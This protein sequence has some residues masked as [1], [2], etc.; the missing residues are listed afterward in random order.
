MLSPPYVVVVVYFESVLS[1]VLL[2]PFFSKKVFSIASTTFC[3]SLVALKMNLVDF[4]CLFYS[5][6]CD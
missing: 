2:A 1:V 5:K 6:T 4:S 3:F